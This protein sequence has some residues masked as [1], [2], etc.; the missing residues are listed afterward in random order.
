MGRASITA[1]LALPRLV[2][3]LEVRNPSHPDARAIITES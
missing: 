1:W 3:L 2:L